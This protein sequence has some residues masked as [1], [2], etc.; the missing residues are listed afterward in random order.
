[1]MCL[2]YIIFNFVLF[3]LFFHLFLCHFAGGLEEEQGEDST[4]DLGNDVGDPSFHA[5]GALCQHHSGNGRVEVSA[6]DGAA[7]V[8]GDCEGQTN[9]ESLA[10]GEDD[11]EEDKGSNE[12]GDNGKDHLLF[13]HNKIFLLGWGWDNIWYKI[14]IVD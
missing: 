3:I 8:D 7:K 14:T 10:G 4:K 13:N 5:D 2:F 9:G 11:S 6:A 12:F 1:M